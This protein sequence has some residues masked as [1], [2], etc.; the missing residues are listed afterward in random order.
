MSDVTWRAVDPAAIGM[1]RVQGV[2][3][4]FVGLG[5][6]LVGAAVG[7]SVVASWRIGVGF[8]IV[9]IL[10]SVVQALIWPSLSWRAFRFAVR[11]DALLVRQGVLFQQ[12]VAVPRHRIQHADLRQGPIER[13]FGL[14]TLAL[15]TAA[16]ISVDASIPGLDEDVAEQLRDE[17]LQRSEPGDGGV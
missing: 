6:M 7:L 11:D 5:P 14:S 8:G 17:L 16:G 3:R 13:A 15:Y 2:I 4:T 1:W 12:T 10:L 9:G